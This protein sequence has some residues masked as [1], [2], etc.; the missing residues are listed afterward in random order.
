MR[1]QPTPKLLEAALDPSFPPQYHRF[2]HTEVTVCC[3]RLRNGHYSVGIST[4]LSSETF[5]EVAGRQIALKKAKD[6]MWEPM[7]FLL[8]EKHSDSKC[9][10]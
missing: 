6:A 4:A 8:A 10:P 7:A 9:L 5:N 2:P 3:L 1:P